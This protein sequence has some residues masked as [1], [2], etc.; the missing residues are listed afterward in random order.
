MNFINTSIESER[1]TLHL[2]EST[3]LD[4]VHRLHSYPEVDE[5]NTLGIP[6]NK[7]V[8]QEILD[9]WIKAGS[10]N[11][12][13]QLTFKV[14]SKENSALIGLFG[15]KLWPKK[16]CRAEVWFVYEPAVYGQGYGT[17]VLRTMLRFGFNQLQLHRIQAGCAVEN[18]ASRRVLEKVGMTQEGRGR[19]ILPLKTGWSDNFEYSILESDPIL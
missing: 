17:E 13:S 9:S 15:L 7:Q 12:P 3:D 16:Y 14:R 5:Y 2:I 1:T 11:W 4:E 6:E 10:T 19:E 18:I 8:T